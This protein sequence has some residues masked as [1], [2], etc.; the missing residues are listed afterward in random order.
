MW[1]ARW[2][3]Y[4]V[5][6]DINDTTDLKIGEKK[7]SLVKLFLKITFKIILNAEYTNALWWTGGLRDPVSRI[8]MLAVA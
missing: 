2:L 3:K 8:V 5:P 4:S 7:R 6:F 1:R